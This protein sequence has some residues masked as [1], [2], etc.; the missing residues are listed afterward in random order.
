M[1]AKVFENYSAFLYGYSTLPIVSTVHFDS[2]PLKRFKTLRMKLNPKI[3]PIFAA[4]A[5]GSGAQA[6][7]VIGVINFSSGPGG[8]VILQDSGG[9][10]TTNL[11]AATGVKEWVS[12]EVD[13]TSG[14]FISVPDGQSV[15][16]SQPWVFD[17]STPTN[18]FWTIPGFGDFTLSLTSTTVEFRNSSFLFISATGTLTGTNFDATPAT[19]LF[20]TQGGSSDG[21]FS[22]SSETNAIPETSSSLL[23]GAAL[24]GVC[25]RRSRKL[26]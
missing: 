16:L 23:L 11:A 26:T 5:L 17:P 15:S 19:W 4:I 10:A 20:S 7:S 22:W 13:T 9:N 18:I 8:G 14:A 21:K 24:L 25:F 2:F 1:N 12:T 3:P 6:A